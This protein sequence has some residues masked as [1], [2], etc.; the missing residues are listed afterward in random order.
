[1]SPHLIRH[2]LSQLLCPKKPTN[3]AANFTTLVAIALV[4]QWTGI[5]RGICRAP[6][7]PHSTRR[8]P[9]PSSLTEETSR[10]KD[11]ST[12]QMKLFQIISY[13]C[14]KKKKNPT[15]IKGS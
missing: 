2:S 3:T 9:L 13:R 4:V 10:M 11:A 14:K 12:E 1:M 6:T 5:K 15:Y 8:W 7:S